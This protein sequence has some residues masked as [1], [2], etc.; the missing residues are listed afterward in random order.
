MVAKHGQLGCRL[1]AYLWLTRLLPPH[2]Y[3]GKVLLLAVVGSHLPLIALVVYV[4]AVARLPWAE[5]GPVLAVALAATLL[6]SALTSAGLWA[7]LAPA[8]LASRALRSYRE[9]GMPP[10]LPTDIE[11]EG[12]RLLA[13]V[14]LTIAAIDRELRLLHGLASRDAL[15]G[16]PNRPEAE[17]RLAA[18]WSRASADRHPFALAAIDTDGLKRVNDRWGHPVGDACLRQLA[19]AFDRHLGAGGWAARWG[20]DEFVA[21]IREAADRPSAEAVV[22]GLRADLTARPVT[23]PGGGQVAVGLSAGVARPTPREDARALFARADAALYAA[24]ARG[25]GTVVT[26]PP[27]A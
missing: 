22:E 13:D 10:A 15:T 12:G 26:A 4:L 18:E 2:S 1:R 16:L 3:L 7:L 17:A 11:D 9:Q 27:P 23:L 24:K 19:A 21:V 20:G 14:Q 5:A 6:G 8:A 25:G